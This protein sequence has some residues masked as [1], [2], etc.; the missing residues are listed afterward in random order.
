[1]A[2]VQADLDRRVAAVWGRASM[3]A[4]ATAETGEDGR[5]AGDRLKALAAEIDLDAKALRDT[6]ESAWP[7]GLV[8]PSWIAKRRTEPAKS[9]TLHWRA[10]VRSSTSLSVP[11]PA[12]QP[13]DRSPALP[14]ALNPFFS[15]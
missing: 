5:E 6:L 9:S 10:G 12:T 13:G 14:S 3:D 8:V 1:M 15:K 2:A 11:I 4:D 7:F